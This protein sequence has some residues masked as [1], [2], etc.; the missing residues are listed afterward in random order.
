MAGKIVRASTEADMENVLRIYAHEVKHGLSTFEEQPPDLEEMCRRRDDV[1]ALGLPHLVAE[2]D[3]AIVGY[4]YAGRYR[5][6]PAYGYTIEN[7]V[8]VAEGMRGT[9]TGKMLLSA[10]IEECERGPWRQ[11]IAV[12]GDAGNAGSIGLHQSLGFRQ[13]GTLRSVGFKLGRWVDT[14]IMQR[15][16]NDGDDTLPGSK[17]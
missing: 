9:G 6:R 2:L 17:A 7:S 5:P 16:L 13:V 10:L 4:A 12:I 15:S 14:V 11:M 8:Y 1:L 3:G